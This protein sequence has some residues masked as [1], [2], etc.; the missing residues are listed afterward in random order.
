MTDL[1]EFDESETILR[2][3]FQINL[4]YYQFNR[5]GGRLFNDIKFSEDLL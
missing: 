3:L 4:E 1:D 5:I 2:T